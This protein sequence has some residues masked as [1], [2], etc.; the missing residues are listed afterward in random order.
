MS[1]EDT[2][3]AE[4]AP[5]TAEN[6]SLRIGSD[7]RLFMLRATPLTIPSIPK[8]TRNDGIRT[9]TAIR[10]LT[11]PIAAPTATAAT[12]PTKNPYPPTA[13][14]ATRDDSAATE[15]TDRSISA[16][17]RA[18][19]I[20]TAMTAIGAACRPILSRLDALRNPSSYNVTAKTAKMSAAVP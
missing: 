18:N 13:S 8:V 20:P 12:A 17:A 10:P 1:S 3:P 15:P 7:C 4:P 16:A 14:A 5:K 19:V 11:S 9:F 2:G 6:V